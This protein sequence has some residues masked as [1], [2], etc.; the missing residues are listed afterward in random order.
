MSDN[1]SV[2]NTTNNNV[3]VSVAVGNGIHWVAITPDGAKV[4]VANWNYGISGNVSIIDTV[5]NKVITNVTVG[6]A[7]FG[8]AVTH[9]G[10]SICGKPAQQQCLSNQHHKQCYITTVPVGY[11]PTGVAITYDDAKVYVA[12]QGS[13]NESV[14]DI[15]T[16]KVTTNVSVGNEPGAFGQFIVSGKP[17]MN[18]TKSAI[19][20]NPADP[21]TYNAVGQQI[22]YTYTVTNTGNVPIIEPITVYDNKI[23]GGSITV[24]T[25]G[26]LLAQGASVQG[27]YTYTVTQADI[28]ADSVTNLANA[29][30]SYNNQPVLSNNTSVTVSAIQNPTLKIVKSI[31]PTSYYTVGQTITYIYNVTNSGNVDISAPITVSDN[32]FSTVPIQSSGI[33]SPGSSVSGTAAYKI[34]DADINTGSV[35]IL[36]H[37]IGLFSGETINSPNNIAVVRYEQPTNGLWGYISP[38]RW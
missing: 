21:T 30:G 26:N 2:I 20:N 19:T 37:S 25:I 27:S 28:D 5:T 13:D 3:Y 4:Y 10:K 38:L 11:W 31:Y 7:P 17:A 6:S 9:D 24:G 33:L 1:V 34:T 14:I 22:T 23:P 8:V 36:A 29:T 18:I 35:T 15:A 12:N 32:K 16:N